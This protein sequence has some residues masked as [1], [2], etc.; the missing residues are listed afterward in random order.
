MKAEVA[1]MTASLLVQHERYNGTVREAFED[2]LDDEP[3]DVALLLMT[4]P[5][6]QTVCS[7]CF[8]L[9]HKRRNKQ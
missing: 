8:G 2:P 6:L 5:N 4:T 9:F 1:A 7:V 3:L